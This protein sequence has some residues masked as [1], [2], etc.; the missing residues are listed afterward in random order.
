MQDFKMVSDV[1]KQFRDL[2]CKQNK[3]F[4]YAFAKFQIKILA[5]AKET[6]CEFDE[7]EDYHDFTVNIPYSEI[8]ELSNVKRVDRNNFADI[9][10][11]LLSS[12]SS[13]D[14][15]DGDSVVT[16]MIYDNIR[17]DNVQ[18]KIE[19]TFNDSVIKLLKDST[20]LPYTNVLISDLQKIKGTKEL[21]L[22]LYSLTIYREKNKSG[23]VTMNINN[24]RNILSDNSQCEDKLFYFR[25]IS[26]P[27]K[28]LNNIKGLSKHLKSDR[29]KQ[30]I[31]L[32]IKENEKN[33]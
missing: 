4:Y 7:M 6:E 22:F 19:V 26:N 3:L 30:N 21:N 8:A 33:G 12:A 17:F 27:I 5:I 16:Y 24:L 13:I 28:K 29:D 9:K 1:L 32:F 15:F 2:T 11:K 10:N 23:V 25:F 31:K 18:R 20:T 14:Y